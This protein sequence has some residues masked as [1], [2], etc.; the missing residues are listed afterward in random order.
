MSNGD[1][2]AD[3]PWV[4]KWRSV[5]AAKV[6]L[7][8]FPHAGGTA[9]MVR[10]WTDLLPDWCDVWA[11]QYPGRESRF[12]EMPHDRAEPLA[13]AIATAIAPRLRGPVFFFGHSMG[14]LLAFLVTQRLMAAGKPAPH[15][16]I[17]AGRRAP[18][19]PDPFEPAHRLPEPQFIARLRRLNGT[20]PEIFQHADLMEI[21][22]PMLR[23]DF[24]ISET[25]QHKPTLPLSCPLTVLGGTRDPMATRD[26]L[27]AWAAHSPDGMT[28]HMFDGDHF[29]IRSAQAAVLHRVSA[30]AADVAGG[31]L[32]PDLSHQPT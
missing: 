32:G 25:Y 27:C 5:P 2:L 23:A 31:K 21:L 13:D 30:I 1:L 26:E 14:A 3:T 16:L 9:S 15:H 28:M 7:L 22:L 10:R 4:V 17:V 18:H 29:F 8:A 6:T 24:G 20:P 12:T 11:V 19:L